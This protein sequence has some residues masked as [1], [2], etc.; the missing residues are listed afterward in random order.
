MELYLIRHAQ[1]LNNARPEEQ[2][3]EDAPLTEKG[4]RQAAYLADWIV[5]LKL[6]R[7]WTSPFL[8]ALQTTQFL[9]DSTGLRP[10][11]ETDLHEVCGCVAGVT[12]QVMEGRPGMTRSE[13]EAQFPQYDVGKD[14]NESGW[15]K[16]KPC[17]SKA[18]ACRR[19]QAILATTRRE[20]ARTDERVAYVMHG[21]FKILLLKCIDDRTLENPWNTSVTRCVLT[22]DDTGLREFNSVQHLPVDLVTL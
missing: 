9:H 19:A 18:I 5:S 4:R 12:P 20:F 1:S 2:R 8:R 21:D 10:K 17:E 11:V 16:S 14:I 13:I 15:W 3:V 6:T 22:S 7:L